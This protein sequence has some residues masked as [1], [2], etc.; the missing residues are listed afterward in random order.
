MKKSTFHCFILLQFVEVL[1]KLK[2][3]Q[4]LTKKGNLS[5]FFNQSAYNRQ[6]LVEGTSNIAGNFGVNYDFNYKRGCCLG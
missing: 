3:H 4:F 5:F 6:W 2:R 1:S